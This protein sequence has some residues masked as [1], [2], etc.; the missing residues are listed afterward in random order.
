MLLNR[1]LLIQFIYNLL[2]ISILTQIMIYSK[3]LFLTILQR[4]LPIQDNI[5][6]KYTITDVTGFNYQISK[7]GN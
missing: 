6:Q 4:S 2:I 3:K 5:L 7:I 1:A